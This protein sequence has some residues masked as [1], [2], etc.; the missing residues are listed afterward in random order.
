M[1]AVRIGPKHQV[2]IPQE[3][4][5]HLHL[6]AGDFVEAAAEG[7]R[8]VLTPL[9]LAAKAPAARLTPSEQKALLRARAKIE[10]IRKDLPRSRGLTRQEVAG[11]ARAGLIEPEQQYWWTE[12]WQKGE[13][14]TE[15]DRRGRRVLGT[16]DS[17]A[18]MKGA[19]KQRA[20][21]SA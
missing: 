13:R 11:A 18:A 5:K 8:I 1:A 6:S 9:R 4:F 14:A 7:G 19:L 12:E 17:V 21:A 3:V 15:S 2:T 10:Q 20:R 16:F